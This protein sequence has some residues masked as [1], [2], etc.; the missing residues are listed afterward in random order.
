MF[1]NR[2]K[3][4]ERA[5]ATRRVYRVWKVAKLERLNLGFRSSV[6]PF[7]ATSEEGQS[8]TRNTS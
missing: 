5:I 4:G 2:A 8:A 7:L 6:S 1:E 3:R